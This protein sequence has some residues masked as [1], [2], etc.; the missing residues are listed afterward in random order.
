[1]RVCISLEPSSFLLSFFQYTHSI[2]RLEGLE[3]V[4]QG[5]DSSGKPS[6]DYNSSTLPISGSRLDFSSSTQST[7]VK[8]NYSKA[9][10]DPDIRKLLDNK[11]FQ[12]A[13]EILTDR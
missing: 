1:M 3:F 9:D 11:Q 10:Y 8:L 5:T 2:T 4:T 6:I 7:E 13:K 12:E